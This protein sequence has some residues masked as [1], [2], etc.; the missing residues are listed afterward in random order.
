MERRRSHLFA[1]LAAAGHVISRMAS[2]LRP[3][4]QSSNPDAHPLREGEAL[5]VIV[6]D[7]KVVAD[8]NDIA[9]SHS[10]FVRRTFGSL[11]EGAW[12]GTI[13]K[14]SGV[15]TALNSRTFYGNQLPAPQV[16]INAVHAR[17]S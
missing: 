17:F 12:V 7:A 6:L 11:P 3:T 9:L 8:T 15:V 14:C 10:E 13:R 5:L 1:I 4:T 2:S 16:V